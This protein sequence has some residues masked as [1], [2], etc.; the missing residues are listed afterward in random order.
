[1]H[2]QKLAQQIALEARP[3][4]KAKPILP[5]SGPS[6]SFDSP[7]MTQTIAEL[8]EQQEV[9]KLRAQ[10]LDELEA[11][12]RAERQ[13]IYAVTQEVYRLKT[14]LD[15]TVTRISEEE[16][17][18]L[19]RVVKVYTIMSPEGAAHNRREMDDEQ[20][21]RLMTVMKESE[22]APILEAMGQGGK[23]NARRAAMITD[24]LRVTVAPAKA[25]KTTP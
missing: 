16:A 9:V 13:E 3:V 25:K 8:K 20:I 18:N 10:Q 15:S 22:C 21:V 23:E 14:N 2:P 11:R 6:W 5:P 1:L 17:A 24:R 12:L 7:E 19:K 4:K